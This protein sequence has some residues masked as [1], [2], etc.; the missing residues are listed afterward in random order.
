MTTAAPSCLLCNYR[1][2]SVALPAATPTTVDVPINGAR[3][4]VVVIKNIGDTNAV[5]ALTVAVSPL[6]TLFEAPASVTAGLPLAA[7]DALPG[8][9]GNGEPVTTLRLVLT[10]T[11]GTTVSIEAGGW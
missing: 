11:S 5:T 8:L 6:G 7:G 9:R 10:S 4:W 3:W 2:D 1:D